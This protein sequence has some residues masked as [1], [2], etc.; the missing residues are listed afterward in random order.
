ML[1][2]KKIS[3]Y[4]SFTMGK[5]LLQHDQYFRSTTVLIKYCRFFIA[6]NDNEVDNATT[7]TYP[8]Y[9]NWQNIEYIPWVGLVPIRSDEIILTSTSVGKK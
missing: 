6:S 5:I 1:K 4:F 7:F 8:A 3:G 2:Y 9:K